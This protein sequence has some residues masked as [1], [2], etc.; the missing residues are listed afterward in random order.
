MADHPRSDVVA[1][2]GEAQRASAATAASALSAGSDTPP[3]RHH[4][5]PVSWAAVVTITVGFLVGGAGLV[6]GPTWWLFWLGTGLTAV[7]GIV[8]LGTG[9]FDDWY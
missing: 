7:G 4:G 8:A 1:G 3:A 2:T 9:I 5:R 6:F